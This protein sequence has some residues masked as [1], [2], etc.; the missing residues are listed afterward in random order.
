M[1]EYE[2]GSNV[3][4]KLSVHITT[5]RRKAEDRDAGNRRNNQVNSLSLASC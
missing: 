2:G 1:R 4:R 5:R 3:L